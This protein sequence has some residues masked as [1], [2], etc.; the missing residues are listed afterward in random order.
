[1]TDH[2]QSKIEEALSQQ[3]GI[4][5]VTLHYGLTQDELF[6]AAIENDKGRVSRWGYQSASISNCFRGRWPTCLL[7]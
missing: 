5:N 1:M 6:Y 2:P 3:F 7:Q 4:K